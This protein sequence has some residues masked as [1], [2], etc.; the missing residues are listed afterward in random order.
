MVNDKAA[1][2]WRKYLNTGSTSDY[3]ALLNVEESEVFAK[4]QTAVIEYQNINVPNVINGTMTWEDY[5]KGLDS[6]SPDDVVPMLQKYV[7]LAK[8]ASK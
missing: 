6:I 1:K 7:D 3:S 5:V 4:M 2:E 8:A